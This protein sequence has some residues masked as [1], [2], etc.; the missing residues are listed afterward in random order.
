MKEQSHMAN[1]GQPDARIV[2]HE[3]KQERLASFI[4]DH[5]ARLTADAGPH[6][7]QLNAVVRS[8]SSPVAHALANCANAFVSE[9]LEPSQR[10]THRA[11]QADHEETGVAV[12][13]VLLIEDETIGQPMTG[14]VAPADLSQADVRYATHGR[15]VDAHEQLVISTE[16]VWIGDCMRRDPAKLDAYERFIETDAEP[17]RWAQM[18]FNRLWDA[19]QVTCTGT[20]HGSLA[21]L[22]GFDLASLAATATIISDSGDNASRN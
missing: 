8:A 22:E 17:V 16:A 10:E 1:S 2:R 20:G 11:S 7:V 14:T 3:E 18:A 6:T 19:S 9:P 4:S 13:I 21:D 5:L 15:L 12:R